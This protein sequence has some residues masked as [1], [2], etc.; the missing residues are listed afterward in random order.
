[1][2]FRRRLLLT[3]LSV[4]IVA[5]LMMAIATLDAI[6]RD[7]LIRGKRELDVGLA[8]TRQLI[9]ER[10]RQLRDQLAMLSSDAGFRR[11]LEN[12]DT[13]A[14]TGMLADRGERVGADRAVLINAVGK[15]MA[16]S[17]LA[18][19]TALLS[20]PLWQQAWQHGQAEGIL[21]QDGAPYQFILLPVRTP[22]PIGWV[23][24]GFLLDDQLASR[25]A[26]LTR[27]SVSFVTSAS[28]PQMAFVSGAL[29][30]AGADRLEQLHRALSSGRDP[31]RQQLDTGDDWL[32]GATLLETAPGGQVHAVVQRPRGELL[33]MFHQLGWQL[34]VISILSLILIVI[35]VAL[36]A[37]SLAR[38]LVKLADAA[39]RIGQGE[40]FRG[41]PIRERGSIGLLAAT[42]EG[43][44]DD[45]DARENSLLYRARH[46]ELTHLANRTCAQQDIDTFVCQKH[47]FTLLRLA[48]SGFRHINDTFGFDMGD[49][50][51]LALS[52]RLQAL[53][54]PL[55]Q[56]YRIGGDEFL[57]ILNAE[58]VEAL[59]LADLVGALS[60]PIDL[61]GSPIRPVFA[62]G[63]VNAPRHGDD[64]WLLLRRAEIA[65]SM[66]HR[67]HRHHLRYV[68]GQDELQQ[69]QLKLVRDLQGAVT[70][71][72]LFMVYQPQIAAHSGRLTGFEALMRW[73][74][75][76]FGF[77]P[78]DEFISLAEQFGHMT[79]LSQWM[80]ETVCH[81]L[82][83]WNAL[84]H[85]VRVAINLSARDVVDPALS[86]RLTRALTTHDVAA[87]QLTLEVTESTII[88]DPVLA[89]SVLER[90]RLA[91]VRIAIDDYGTGYSSLSQLR[92][93]P[94]RE[95]KIDK[96]FVLKLDEREEDR[97]IV[98]STIEL[99]HNL[100][101]EV[102]AEGVETAASRT[103]LSQLGCNYLQ[104]YLIS[105]PLA[106]AAVP[107]WIEHNQNH[108]V[109]LSDQTVT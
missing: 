99:G 102:V 30:A 76:E 5:Q 75:P 58:H 6:R 28:S 83:E 90:L 78:P 49:R 3:M 36:S 34:L 89:V 56:A 107:G 18:P 87:D 13:A 41:M 8:V 12:S 70:E 42:L 101:L 48:I 9:E 21:L 73:Q 71:Q 109:I 66:A 19:G 53:P 65:M 95:L 22:S 68:E 27:L 77:V 88:Q 94:V 93:L 60:Q 44:Q 79:M 81:Q 64:A 85:R 63:E 108:P 80:I 52:Q 43:M 26:H 106:A 1:M 31:G 39:R 15:I 59:W 20:T 25:I 46:D 17:H 32:T 38:S 57:L 16:G 92:T 33:A 96:S 61:D 29:K 2:S 37:R 86:E 97:I 98:R 82:A 47:A 91:G 45:L 104:G 84:G 55:H 23:G 103:L 62:I 14:L 7:E 35:A 54:P 40:R 50:V 4:V 72:Q 51:L 11:A 74:H 100:G 24:M 105:R 10:S 69:R 67:S